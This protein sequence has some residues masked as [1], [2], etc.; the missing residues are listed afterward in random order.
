MASD[1]AW[2]EMVAQRLQSHDDKLDILLQSVSG[3]K[4]KLGLGAGIIATLVSIIIK[5]M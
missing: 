3:M 1:K 4:V 5:F 2:K